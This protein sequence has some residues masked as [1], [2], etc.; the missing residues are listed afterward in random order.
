MEA[1]KNTQHSWREHNSTR[2]S[3]IVFDIIHGSTHVE[4]PSPFR[5]Y[6]A[7]VLAYILAPSSFQKKHNNMYAPP[8][9]ASQYVHCCQ[10]HRF[11]F[12]AI[13]RSAVVVI[14]GR[15]AAGDG[16]EGGGNGGSL[17]IEAETVELG[18]GRA[19]ASAKE[20]FCL[21]THQTL[22]YSTLWLFV[23]VRGMTGRNTFFQGNLQ[24]RCFWQSS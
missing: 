24:C 23:R 6:M 7:H 10:A 17:E 20:N 5:L 13:N 14:D 3:N 12:H 1:G 9:K 22:K 8:P 21:L 19:I 15:E 11:T 16:S 2:K 4:W 18:T